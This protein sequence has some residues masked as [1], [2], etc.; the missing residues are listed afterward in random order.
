MLMSEDSYK[1]MNQLVTMCFN[2]NA[3][4]DNMAYNLDY[5]YHNRIADIVHHSV[6]HI[7]PQWADLVSDRMLTLSARPVRL[8]LGGYQDE[9]KTLDEIFLLM[10]KTFV[11]MRNYVRDIIETSDLNGDDEVRIFAEEFLV[12]V[13]KF[14][15]QAD[16]WCNAAKELDPQKLNIH[17]KD[18]THFIDII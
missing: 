6:A 16:E 14:I 1:M 15:K 7:M 12:N 5:H 17:I 18:Y 10:R 8:P 13:T 4:F 2:A 9:Y 3:V 11:D